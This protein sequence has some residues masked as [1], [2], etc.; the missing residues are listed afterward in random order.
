MHTHSKCFKLLESTRISVS[1]V[2]VFKPHILKQTTH[3]KEIYI[4]TCGNGLQLVFVNDP[5]YLVT[6][7]TLSW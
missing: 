2:T 7:K 5:L 4:F 6:A 1:K 3:I